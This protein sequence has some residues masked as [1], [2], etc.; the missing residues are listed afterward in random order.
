MF[1]KNI[2]DYVYTEKRSFEDFPF[3]RVD[4][5][6]F[7][8]LSYLDFSE[9]ISGLDDDY[10]FISLEKLARFSNKNK[11]FQKTWSVLRNK[12]LLKAIAKSKR[13]K[14]IKVN[15]YSEKYDE[16]AESQF[17]AFTLTISD[18][19]HYI[20]YRGTDTSLVGWKEDF[21]MSCNFPVPAQSEALDY[22][23]EVSGKI[24]GR[25][26]VGGHSKGGNLAVYACAMASDNIQSRIDKIF[27]HDGPG[28]MVDL[29]SDERAKN[30]IDKI[31]HTIPQESV[32]GLLMHGLGEN[33][34]IKSK[35][36]GL[37]QH[38]PFNWL[39]EGDDFIIVDDITP[40]AATVRDTLD[41]WLSGMDKKARENFIQSV[42]SILETVNIR[43]LKDITKDSFAK[44]P[45]VVK[46]I[47]NMDDK[48]KNYV[49]I[50]VKSLLTLMT[51][52]GIKEFS[53]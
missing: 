9:N 21:N 2:I 5:L 4:S 15:F 31:E 23:E 8:Q 18:N 28:F 3:N 38:F 30:V 51:G 12:V 29:S 49:L 19:L 36:Q 45:E 52:I 35:T 25:L 10:D 24:G 40:E 1:S 17:C 47:Q 11:Y 41:E 42:F 37:V 27:S 14:N 33:L 46:T 20:V 16:E 34:V 44:I 39:V 48:E 7:S 53:L 26:M 22:L 50:A 32:V 13:F 6:V 43:D